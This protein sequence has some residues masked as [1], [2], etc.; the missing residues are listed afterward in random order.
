[1][2]E[3]DELDGGGGGGKVILLMWRPCHCVA[4]FEFSEP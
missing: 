1:M 4:K 2:L 3:T